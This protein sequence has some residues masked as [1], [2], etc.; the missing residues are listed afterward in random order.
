VEVEKL[1]D[2]AVLTFT[3]IERET[4]VELFADLVAALDAEGLQPGDPVHDRLFPA[5]YSGH[6]SP[7]VQAQF[8][9]LTEASLRDERIA[10]CAACRDE[11]L[12]ADAGNG[13][14]ELDASGYDRW[15]RVLNDLRLAIGTRLEISEDDGHWEVAPDD[16]SSAAYLLYHWLTEMQEILTLFVLRQPEGG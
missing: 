8:R 16:P 14:I 10:R 5:G 6:V 4:L 1:G 9:E 2:G 3:D 7:E 12:A 13:R 15:L 11:L